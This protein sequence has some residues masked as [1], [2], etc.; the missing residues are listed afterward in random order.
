MCR[1]RDN[2]PL[3][4]GDGGRFRRVGDGER[5]SR[6]SPREILTTLYHDDFEMP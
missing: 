5:R 1:A 2:A 4:A 6:R 3:R